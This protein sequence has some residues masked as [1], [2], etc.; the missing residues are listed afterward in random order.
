VQ[1]KPD[2]HHQEAWSAAQAPLLREVGTAMR[3]FLA[4]G[5]NHLPDREVPAD[6]DLFEFG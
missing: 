2:L 6:G 5:A 1:F 4:R 3:A